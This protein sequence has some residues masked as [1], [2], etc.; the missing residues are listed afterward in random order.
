MKNLFTN[1]AEAAANTGAKW[2]TAKVTD[3]SEAFSGAAKANPDVSHWDT[4]QVTDMKALF[5]DAAEAAATTG[6]KW[7]TGKG[8]DLSEAF[9]GAAKANPDVSHWDTSQVT[10]MKAH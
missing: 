9:S 5:K 8:T 7:N 10:D 2:N 4:S 1:A 6:A 3:L